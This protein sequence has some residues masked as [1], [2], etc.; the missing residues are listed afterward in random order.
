M[1]AVVQRVRSASVRVRGETVSG[2]GRGLLVLVGVA[3][4]DGAE[5]AAWLAR[6]IA[7]L[8]VF[9]AEESGPA[10]S[11]REGSDREGNDG[12]GNDGEGSGRE[13][14]VAEIA[15]EVLAVSQFTLLANCRKGRRPSFTAAAPGPEAE[16]LYE[17]FCA[18]LREGGLPVRT[19][20]FGATME[21]ALANDGPYTLVIESPGARRSILPA[22]G[23]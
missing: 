10:G 9:P 6:R 16:R 7:G 20:V 2:I 11:D 15:G 14:S 19:G 21:V 22:R 18:R 5:D 12:E 1:I 4:G 8:R 17:E 3:R 13:R 23:A